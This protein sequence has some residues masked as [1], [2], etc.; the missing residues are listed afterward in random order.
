MRTRGRCVPDGR[1]GPAALSR[2]LRA[3]ATVLL[4]FTGAYLAVIAVVWLGQERLLFLPPPARPLPPARMGWRIEPVTLPMPDGTRLAGA[5]LLPATQGPMPLVIYFGGNAEDALQHAED[6]PD[7]YGDRAVLLVNYRGYG[8]SEGSPRESLL[9]ADAVAIYDYAATHAGI[10][11]ARIAVHGR[12]LGTGVAVA[13]AAARPAR[14]VMLTSPFTSAR[15]VARALYPWLP[16]AL[17]MRHPFDSAS[18]APNVKAPLLVLAGDADRLVPFTQ[19]QRL[20]ALWGGPVE[21]I[22]IPGAGH[23]DLLYDPSYRRALRA[24]LD[25]RL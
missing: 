24:F 13:L 7:D 25:R 14:C 20:A 10:D 4:C 3:L 22:S 21:V 17:L 8:A 23:E 6:A 2:P 11:P 12:S 15:D 9:H 5:W 19:S 18:H 1:L 16:V